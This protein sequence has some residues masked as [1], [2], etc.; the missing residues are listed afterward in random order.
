MRGWPTASN[1]YQ[2]TPVCAKVPR[3]VDTDGAKF[4]RVEERVMRITSPVQTELTRLVGE[5]LRRLRRE[6]ARPT[7]ASN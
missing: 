5:K 3:I 6:R 7:E 4:H 2:P 1:R